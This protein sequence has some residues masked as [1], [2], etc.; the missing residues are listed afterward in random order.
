MTKLDKVETKTL[1]QLLRERVG[2]DRLFK[3]LRLFLPTGVADT[4]Q[5]K[6]E[7]RLAH[8]PL[9]YLLEQ[10]QGAENGAAPILIN[11]GYTTR[12]AG[13]RGKPSM[14]YKLGEGGAALLRLAGEENV[15]ACQLSTHH[16]LQHA[17]FILDICRAALKAGLSVRTDQRL[18]YGEKSHIRPDNLI[19]LPDGTQAIFESEQIAEPEW[20]TRI[21]ESLANKR[22]LFNSPQ[23]QSV[24]PVIRMIVNASRNQGLVQ[25]QKVWE[26]GLRFVRGEQALPFRLVMLPLSD[27]L[28][29]PDWDSEPDSRR[30]IE[31][32]SENAAPLKN[33]FRGKNSGKPVRPDHFFTRTPREDYLVLLAVLLDWQNHRI[34]PARRPDPMFFKIMRLIY[35]ASHAPGRSFLEEASVPYD[36]LQ[37]LQEYLSLH[38]SLTESLNH[39]INK[40]GGSMRWMPTTMAQRMQTVVNRFLEYHGWIS[41]GPLEV[42]AE[43]AENPLHPNRKFDVLVR[44]HKR[45][46]LWTPQD[47][48]FPGAQEADQAA[49]SL[50]W[51]LRA[52]FEYAHH[53]GISES[54]FW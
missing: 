40:S 18:L 37:L 11:T 44:I 4:G 9:R 38:P 19:T 31:L 13:Q 27:F 53:L 54:G 17:V 16:E 49:L 30:W 41:E 15:R 29:A 5:L 24:S 48:F 26:Q 33:G 3:T 20:I 23:G 7:L 10:I 14:I 46:I 21:T 51:V 1:D 47:E 52:L 39:A 2:G 43:L 32:E 36:S 8:D 22:N 25:T 6:D 45:Q 42:S 12:R 35:S 50:S 34:G 28:A